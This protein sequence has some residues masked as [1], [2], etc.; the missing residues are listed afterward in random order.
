MQ[1]EEVQTSISL[2]EF[3]KTEREKKRVSIEQVAAATKINVKLLSELEKDRF[4]ALPAKP[5]VRGFITSYV[6]FLGLDPKTVFHRYEG[7]LAEKASPQDKKTETETHIFVEKDV[8][9]D[10]SKT[11]LAIIM[12]SIL[13][14]GG[15]A[16]FLLPS[17]KHKKHRQRA[18]VQE[19]T[20][21]IPPLAA[22]SAV[23]SSPVAPA[24][25]SPTGAPSKQASPS[26]AAITPALPAPAPATNATSNAMSSSTAATTPAKKLEPIPP[27]EAKYLLI[28]RALED[29]WVKYQVDDRPIQQYTLKQDKTIFVRARQSIRFSA[30]RPEVLE[31][32]FDNKSFQSYGSKSKLF[33]PQESE[34]QYGA[35]PFID[36]STAAAP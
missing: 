16:Y 20:T 4:D 3:L 15:V 29:S 28:V 6:R 19:Q 2:G 23:V 7:Y 31:I 10:R 8:Q 33:V 5:F 24:A 21:V 34:A 36:V 35:Q 14:L 30:A 9:K 25:S 17:L 26:Q 32:S 1:K 27:N 22:P 12:I 11:F 13:C 18:I